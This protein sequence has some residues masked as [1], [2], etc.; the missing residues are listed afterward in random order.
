MTFWSRVTANRLCQGKAPA[1]P[2]ANKRPGG[3]L[4]LP[5]NWLAADCLTATKRIVQQFWRPAGVG[6]IATVLFRG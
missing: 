2:V 1:D 3:S 5:S 6:A 4:G